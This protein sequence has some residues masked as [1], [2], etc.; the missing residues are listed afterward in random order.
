L[1]NQ[2]EQFLILAYQQAEATVEV[3][4]FAEDRDGLIYLGTLA[5][6]M[7]LQNDKV[8]AL[9]NKATGF[10]SDRCEN[11][12]R[13][14]NGS[15]WINNHSTVIRFSPVKKTFDVFDEKAGL[16]QAGIR[17]GSAYYDPEGIFYFGNQTG[18]SFFHPDSISQPQSIF[19]ITV[20]RID[21][22]GQSFMV[23]PNEPIE[24]PSYGNDIFLHL[25]AVDLD[26]SKNIFYRYRL[27]G[28]DKEWIN[29]LNISGVR[30]N[31]LNPGDYKF[32]LQASGDGVHWVTALYPINLVIKPAYWHTWW[33]RVGT[34]L[35][36]SI[37]LYFILKR[38]EKIIQ[39]Q[40]QEKAK[41]EEM[42]SQALQYQLEIEQVINYF[43]YSL[44]GL[45]SVDDVLWD[46]VKT[47]IS[48]LGFQDCVIYLFNAD[49]T[50]LIQ[51]AAYG[52]KNIGYTDIY[53]RVEILPGSGIVGHVAVTGVSEIIKD[54]SKE[55]RYIIDDAVRLSEIAVPLIGSNGIIGV[56]DSEHPDP[57]FY[58]NR[59]LQ[60]LTAIGNMVV[61]KIEQLK[62]EANSRNKE[63]EMARLQRDVATLQ[64]T[65]T[66]AQMN[67][68]FI[69]NA[70][71]SVQQYIL[72]GNTDEANKYL[73]R[74]SKLQRE[75]LN[76]CDKS[77]ISLQKE[78][79]MLRI[80]L[81]LEQL[82]F[83]GS[84]DFEITSDNGLDSEEIKI[85]P[86]ILQ[87]FV[88]NAIWHGLMPKSGP[89]HVSIGFHLEEED[90]LLYC[91]ICDNG[92]GRRASESNK[93]NSS[94]DK[95][96]VSK[97]LSLVY[98]RLELL[99]EQMGRSFTTR[100]TDLVDDTGNATGTRLML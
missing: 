51:K 57:G 52:P 56:I 24:F 99:Q 90:D 75:I 70:L 80:Y 27:S 7:V 76:H 64:L 98:R 67:P 40:A 83:N 4:D 46:V 11:L 13:D 81:Q 47:C 53:N 22:E 34:A 97:G 35:V 73:S 89:R 72:Q 44:S 77:F 63:V 17:Q 82:R 31:G 88:E 5:G 39:A 1:T 86:M 10:P 78:I 96:Y 15:I 84:F 38:R 32:E 29:E 93:I 95:D 6:M 79:E 49:K 21:H 18:F 92:I 100:I 58:N 74:F 50:L 28:F 71:N 33:F 14:R 2:Q 87:P 3:F 68:H 16:S 12:L 65:A 60:I 55:P 23:N 41:M 19:R 66:R 8:I 26:Q 54:T 37:L 45:Q 30:Y 9:Y 62:A 25:S 59:H 94:R 48:Q 69:F 42:R 61:N 85:P 91:S 43:A 20:N 36:L